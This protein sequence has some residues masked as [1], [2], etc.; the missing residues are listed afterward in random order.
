MILWDEA[1]SIAFT[2]HDAGKNP[3][4]VAKVRSICID[5]DLYLPEEVTALRAAESAK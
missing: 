1:G 5:Y 2:L 3:V 4:S